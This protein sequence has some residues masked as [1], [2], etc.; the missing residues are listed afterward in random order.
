ML[1]EKYLEIRILFIPNFHIILLFVP[2]STPITS[3]FLY[4]YLIVRMLKD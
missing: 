3:D 4:S 1:Y 2:I